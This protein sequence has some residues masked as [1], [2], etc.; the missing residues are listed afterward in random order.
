MRSR[1]IHGTEPSKKIPELVVVHE[2]PVDK[3]AGVKAKISPG[4]P[5]D[6]SWSRK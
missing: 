4:N 3:A 1:I 6:W 2:D 5:F